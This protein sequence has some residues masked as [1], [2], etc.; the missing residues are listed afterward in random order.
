MVPSK[1][2]APSI[3]PA[4]ATLSIPE[5]PFPRG[6]APFDPHAELRD[7]FEPPHLRPNGDATSSASDDPTADAE[8]VLG[9]DVS[10]C[11]T[12]VTQNTLEGTLSDQRLK[13]AIVNGEF[14]RVG[15]TVGG[16]TL[17]SIAETEVR[18]KC[19]DGTVTLRVDTDE[20][21]LEH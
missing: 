15:Q 3:V 7:L 4:A 8:D 21:L 14:V 9:P 17:T 10:T 12:F 1:P 20:L 5:L 16:C 6:L 2:A 18:F 11:A 19:R 13:I